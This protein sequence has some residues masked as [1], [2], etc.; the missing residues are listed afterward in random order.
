MGKSTARYLTLCISQFSLN[1]TKT[2]KLSNPLLM[3]TLKEKRKLPAAHENHVTAGEFMRCAAQSRS[4]CRLQL[5][6]SLFTGSGE[7]HSY[8]IE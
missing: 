7:A 6:D 4:T 3:A 2:H 1:M 5:A 8:H